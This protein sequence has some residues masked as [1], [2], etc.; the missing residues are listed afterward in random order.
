VLA[1]V[2]VGARSCALGC[3]W[4]I[5]QLENLVEVQTAGTVKLFCAVVVALAEFGAVSGVWH[6]LGQ[7]P[8]VLLT[9]VVIYAVRAIS[10]NINFI[11]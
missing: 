11:C 3:G 7:I 2:E 8:G 1:S 6:L 9:S 5:A 10:E 4:P